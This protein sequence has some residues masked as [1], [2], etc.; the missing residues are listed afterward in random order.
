MRAPVRS[1]ADAFHIVVGSAAVLAVS[2]AFGALLGPAV[3]IALVVGAVAGALIW[4]VATVDPGHRQTLR[5]A[6]ADGQAAGTAD[7]R[8]VLVV[9]NRTLASDTLRA[10]LVRRA[11][12]GDV[13]RLV[14][15]IVSSR[16][17]YVASDI[18]REL[19][20][21]DQRVRDVLA[22]AQQQGM[23]ISARVGDPNVALGAIE[24]ELRRSRA[25]EVVVSTL[26]P[27]RS[28]WLETGI[29]KRLRAELEIPVT[30]VIAD[31]ERIPTSTVSR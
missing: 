1:E 10:E 22:W 16:A 3:G 7:R 23:A 15:P 25:D 17:H 11:A 2:V 21:A 5:E 29:L 9:A 24:D 13:L 31:P 8:Y 4:E 19:R 28:N 12:A 26:P 18:D 6:A 20:E 30:H 27:D 14:A